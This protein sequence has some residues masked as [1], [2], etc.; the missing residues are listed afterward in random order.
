[1]GGT[2]PEIRAQIEDLIAD[3]A[4]LIDEDA[5][6]EWT[7]LFVKD[8]IYRIT[9]RENYDKDLPISLVFCDSID[10]LRDRVKSL[11]QANI[12]NIHYDRHLVAGARIL[13]EVH[14]VFDVHS[15]YALYQTNMEGR[16]S[17]YSVGRY[18]DKVIFD[19]AGARF[20]ERVVVA[21]TAGIPNL[22]ATPI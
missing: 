6:E 17:L 14:G 7:E 8:S 13:Q 22:L 10:M 4:R 20:K 18:L 3:A 21:D 9:T 5:L 11:R 2:S 12:Y 1:M 16:S 19:G 15:S